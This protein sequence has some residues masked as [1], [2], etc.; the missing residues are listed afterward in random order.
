M[1]RPEHCQANEKTLPQADFPIPIH[2]SMIALALTD[3]FL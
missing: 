3:V 1:I 2:P